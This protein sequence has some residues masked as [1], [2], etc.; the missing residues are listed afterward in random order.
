MSNELD[1]AKMSHI[2]QSATQEIVSNTE[3]FLK[4]VSE[5]SIGIDTVSIM[6]NG[7]EIILNRNDYNELKAQNNAIR[8]KMKIDIKTLT[9]QFKSDIKNKA[10]NKHSEL[11]H[12][13]NS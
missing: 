4:Y 9:E 5:N 11:S 7:K 12:D 6:M 3:K 13:G 8:L 2:I 10:K 1:S